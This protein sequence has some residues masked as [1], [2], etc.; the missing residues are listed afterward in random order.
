[1]ESEGLNSRQMDERFEKE[2]DEAK[3]FAYGIA[4]EIKD[5]QD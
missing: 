1:M 5:E 3:R 2:S 4:K